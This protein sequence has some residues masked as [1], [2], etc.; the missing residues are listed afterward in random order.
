MEEELTEEQK[1]KIIESLESIEKQLE[2]IKPLCKN[3]TQKKIV[4]IFEEFLDAHR[5]PHDESE[6][7][8]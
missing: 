3:D 2:E 7:H 8:K 4:S 6:T 5:A 1:Q